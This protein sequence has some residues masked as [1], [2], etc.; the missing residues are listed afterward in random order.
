MAKS[1]TITCDVCGVVKGSVNHWYI[2]QLTSR[3]SAAEESKPGLPIVGWC[4]RLWQENFNEDDPHVKHVCG[5]E[6]SHK[7]LDEFFQKVQR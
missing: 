7:L 4:I 6:C 1:E 5:Q 3:Y 2:V